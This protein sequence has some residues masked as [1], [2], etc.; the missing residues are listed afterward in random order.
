[1]YILNSEFCALM[2]ILILPILMTS[3]PPHLQLSVDLNGQDRTLSLRAR[4][5]DVPDDLVS[6]A[7]ANEA[8]ET[9]L[10]LGWHKVALSVRRDSVSLLVDCNPIETQP[11]EPRGKLSTDGHTLLAIRA[12]DAGPVQ[13]RS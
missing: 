1:M 5:A 13:V 6:C 7:F 4:R 8:V 10:D 12:T 2:P 3:L 9:L 11:L